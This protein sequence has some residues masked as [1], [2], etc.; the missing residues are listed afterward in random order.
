MR[1]LEVLHREKHEIYY[2][3]FTQDEYKLIVNEFFI[4][5]GYDLPLSL[6][7]KSLEEL[8]EEDFRILFEKIG[9]E[10]LGFSEFDE[11]RHLSGK[12]SIPKK[13]GEA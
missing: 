7:N 2:D 8:E 12:F 10:V 5:G 9:Y 6:N 11:K 1:V 4:Q 13:T 3:F